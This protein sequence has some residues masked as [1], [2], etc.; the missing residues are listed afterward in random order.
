MDS[1]V[2]KASTVYIEI[3]GRCNGR[4][5]YCAQ[6]RLKQAKH[7]G[8]IMSPLL[9]E[10]ILDY[11][12]EL[13][14][15]DKVNS[16]TIHLYNWGE[17]FLN[18]EIN[19]ILQILKKKKLYAGISSNFIVKPDIDKECLPIIKYLKLSL[20]GFSQD[21]YGKIHGASLEKV[22]NNFE[23]F[24]VKIR[25]YSPQTRIEI[26][27]HRYLFNENEFW[28]AYRYFNRPGIS[29]M[30]IIAHLNDLPEMIDF[31]E[32][33]LSEDRK[34]QAEKDIFLNHT[35]KRIAYHKKKSKSYRC[36]A[37][38]FLVIDEI[39]QLLLCCGV[40]GYD[41]EYVLGN[42]LE[43]SAE[44][45]WNSKFSNSFCNKCLSLGLARWG[46]NQ[47]IGGFHDK[48]WPPGGGLHYLKLWFH[49]NLTHPLRVLTLRKLPGVTKKWYTA[50]K[51]FEK[52]TVKV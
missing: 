20:S 38:N 15:L 50:I 40:T 22:L 29:F 41:S 3:S 43:M 11:L 49:W 18:H 47:D 48:P 21:S 46:Y 51:N 44:E 23:D 32:D 13:E 33:G 52:F 25:K 39:G 5:P 35:R 28:A 42:I 17:P 45:I 7:F 26:A 19:D 30:P 10:Q 16:Y 24:Y 6:R 1:N 2:L 12:F 14:L 4:C 34:K 27:W 36:P 31:L 37:R 9:F 8:G